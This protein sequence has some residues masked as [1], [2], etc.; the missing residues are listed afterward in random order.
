MKVSAPAIPQPVEVTTVGTSVAVVPAVP[1]VAHWASRVILAPGVNNFGAILFRNPA[2]SGRFVRV[3]GLL[4]YATPAD[5]IGVTVGAEGVDLVD[6]GTE[7]T[8]DTVAGN[9]P[10]A[11]ISSE[12][13]GVSSGSVFLPASPTGVYIPLDIRLLDGDGVRCSSFTANVG[14]TCV[15]FWEEFLL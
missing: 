4:F 13:F 5:H 11:T 1:S 8:R 6:L 7:V 12:I 14:F 10:V 9:A 2:A 3:T 15:F